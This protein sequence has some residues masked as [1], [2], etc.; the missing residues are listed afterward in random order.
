MDKEHEPSL[1]KRGI[2]VYTSSA[3]LGRP[4]KRTD[5]RRQINAGGRQSRVVEGKSSLGSME[6]TYENY[7]GTNSSGRGS[8]QDS[9]YGPIS[10][11]K[12]FLMSQAKETSL[13]RRFVA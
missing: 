1:D 2:G 5:K 11:G 12:I 9:I 8:T 4:I 6:S 13:A 10:L 7:H 3:G